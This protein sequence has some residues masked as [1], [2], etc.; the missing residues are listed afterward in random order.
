VLWG[1]SSD[2]ELIRNLHIANDAIQMTRSWSEIWHTCK[3]CSCTYNVIICTYDWLTGRAR[4][5]NIWF[6]VCMPWRRAKYFPICLTTIF[7]L[8]I[9][10]QCWIYACKYLYSKKCSSVYTPIANEQ[11]MGAGPDG[12]FQT[13]LCQL[14]Q[15]YTRRLANAFS[16]ELH[17]WG[18]TVV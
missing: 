8:N 15:P 3:A 2:Y 4:Q 5:E 12:F 11:I 16:M 9:I 1:S 6:E 7:M 10:V 13:S 17:Q 18:W 14:V